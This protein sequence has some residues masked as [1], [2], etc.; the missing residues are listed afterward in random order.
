[1]RHYLD[2]NASAPMN[3]HVKNYV[4]EI[5]EVINA[6]MIALQEISNVSDFNQLVNK[7]DLYNGYCTNTSCHDIDKC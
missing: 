2:Y 4:K 6:E 7:L 3:E 1:M 5:I